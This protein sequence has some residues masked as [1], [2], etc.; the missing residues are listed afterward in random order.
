MDKI[1]KIELNEI[2]KK[3][4]EMRNIYIKLLS[5]LSD[6]NKEKSS[7]KCNEFLISYITENH[8][9]KL[10]LSFCNMYNEL[11]IR[12]TNSFLAGNNQLVLPRVN[13][14]TKQIDCYL[15]PRL[16]LEYLEISDVFSIL[17]PI[18]DICE[19]IDINK[20]SLIIVPGLAFDNQMNRLGR[21]KGYYDKLFSQIKDEDKDENKEDKEDRRIEK[22]AICYEIQKSGDLLPI[23][24]H[25]QKI[26]KIY[27]F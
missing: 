10:I 17:E 16:T 22:I 2:Q 21:G 6:E 19:L 20:I 9:N 14:Q 25:D 1:Y 27:A 12:E 7:K 5:G 18:P 23:E 13:K 24:S 26:D 4:R 8:N 15:V 3:K 11:N